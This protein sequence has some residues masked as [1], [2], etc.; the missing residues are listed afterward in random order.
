[1]VNKLALSDE[2]PRNGHV[3]LSASLSRDP[4]LTKRNGSLTPQGVIMSQKGFQHQVP[5]RLTELIV[6][7]RKFE[8][9]NMGG[10][11]GDLGR[12]G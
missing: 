11:E 4:S 9:E 10:S 2:N 8:P 3:Y 6:N 12:R 5:A 7:C 1:M